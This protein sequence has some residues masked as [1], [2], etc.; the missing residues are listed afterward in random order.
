[1]F[2]YYANESFLVRRHNEL[3]SKQLKEGTLIKSIVC[4]G[5]GTAVGL[6]TGKT[7][8]FQMLKAYEN[9]VFGKIFPHSDLVS[10]I[11][12][13]IYSNKHFKNGYRLESVELCK[14]RKS[15]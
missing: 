12:L 7:C 11:S 4:P 14:E 5:L 13:G 2:A 1:M 6:L 3:V 8:A 9:V 10:L 15:L